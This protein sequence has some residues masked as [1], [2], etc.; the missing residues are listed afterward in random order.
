M[1]LNTENNSIKLIIDCRENKLISAMKSDFLKKECGHVSFDTQQLDVG[2]IIYQLNGLILCLIE[3]KTV[4]DYASSIV[5]KR[6]KN[7]SMRISQLKKSNPN[8]FIIYIIEGNHLHKDHKFRNGITR[9]A[10]YSSLM[11]RLFI[12]KFLIYQTADINDTS[13]II[14]KIYDKLPEYFSQIQTETFDER[15]EYLKTIKLAKKENMTPNNCYLFQLSQIPGVSIEIAN[16]IS[17][18]YQSMVFL[19]L[20]Y[21][22]QTTIEEKE[23]LL[24]N[25]LLPIANNKSKRLGKVLSKRIYEYLYGINQI[26]I[27]QPLEKSQI[28]LKLTLKSKIKLK[29]NVNN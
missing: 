11:N 19:I 12:D 9:N 26:N 21:E 24:A 29:S 10:F 13:L 16:L 2:D 7:Q 14:T 18:K 22:K 4:D 15:L 5:D 1:N 8:I 27:E 23:T 25:I 6:L 3:R 28:Q 20:T 17:K